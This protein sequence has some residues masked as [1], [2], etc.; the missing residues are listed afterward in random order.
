MF[1][2]FIALGQSDGFENIFHLTNRRWDFAFAYING[3]RRLSTLE[4]LHKI[5]NGWRR[6]SWSNKRE[7]GILHQPRCR[8]HITTKGLS[9]MRT[10][11][12]DN[13]AQ[14]FHA[15]N[16]IAIRLLLSLLLCVCHGQ[17][18]IHCDS[19]FTIHNS[20][21]SS[22]WTKC[23]LYLCALCVLT[24]IRAKIQQTCAFK[25]TNIYLFICLQSWNLCSINE[26]CPLANALDYQHRTHSIERLDYDNVSG[27]R[28]TALI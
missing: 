14:H 10:K 26:L 23:V 18:S 7:I 1:V 28:F 8:C 5:P 4:S 13:K 11:A 15:A 21:G 17:Y 20:N 2:H 25:W 3:H 27:F 22:I 9:T 24:E 16:G 19:Q 12:L 6:C